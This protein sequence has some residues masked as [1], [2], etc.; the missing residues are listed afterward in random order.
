MYI[1]MF[2][3][4]VFISSVLWWERTLLEKENNPSI[5]EKNNLGHLGYKIMKSL[6]SVLK[7]SDERD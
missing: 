4:C 2:N 3:K 7:D 6:S 5:L 1:K